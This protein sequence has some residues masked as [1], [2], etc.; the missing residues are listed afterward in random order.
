MPGE[1]EDESLRFDCISEH[2]GEIADALTTGRLG[3]L[4]SVKMTPAPGAYTRSR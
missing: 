1:E 3:L 4:A 2:L